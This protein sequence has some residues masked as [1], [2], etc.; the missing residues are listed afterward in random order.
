MKTDEHYDA[1]FDETPLCH[2]CKTSRAENQEHFHEHT[3]YFIVKR[4]S[5][6]LGYKYQEKTVVIPRCHRCYEQHRRWGCLSL[7]IIGPISYAGAGLFLYRLAGNSIYSEDGSWIGFAFTTFLFGTAVAGGLMWLANEFTSRR[8]SKILPDHDIEDY[9]L[10]AALRSEGW[11]MNKP[12][13]SSFPE[14][15]KERRQ[16]D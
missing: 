10:V 5:I 13:P 7:L 3:M 6:P 14:T 11:I 12:D 1:T 2:Y 15:G 16:H 9:P 4:T 8:F